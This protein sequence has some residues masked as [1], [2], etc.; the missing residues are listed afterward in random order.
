M[1]SSRI[2]FSEALNKQTEF[3]NKLNDVKIGK[4]TPEQKK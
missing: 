4:K 1:R 2:K 3:L